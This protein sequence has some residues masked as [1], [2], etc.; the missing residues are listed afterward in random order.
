MAKGCPDDFVFYEKSEHLGNWAPLYHDGRVFESACHILSLPNKKIY[1]KM[2]DLGFGLTEL[3]PQPLVYN[4][5]SN[6]FTK[7]FR[8]RDSLYY[9]KQKLK[10]YNFGESANL[11]NLYNQKFY[12]FKK[13][14][15][16]LKDNHK[17]PLIL[18]E[19]VPEF[20]I[21]NS[22]VKI[23]SKSFESVYAT[24]GTILNQYR[25]IDKCYSFSYKEKQSVHFLIYVSNPNFDISYI[26][27]T[28]HKS[29][30]RLSRADYSDK[31]Y[32]L[33]AGEWDKKLSKEVIDEF[34]KKTGFCDDYIIIKES[35][36]TDRK[37][38]TRI[39]ND[40]V[41]YIY[42]G[43]KNLMGAASQIFK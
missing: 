5:Q 21:S 31:N 43:G 16:E 13:G 10:E 7:Y 2:I 42:W 18:K 4:Y 26:R 3:K 9:A 30:F 35:I 8:F 33:L 36:V 14:S 19:N 28:G 27:I 34:F 12:Y 25:V 15:F 40:R 6:R 38:T 17:K 24:P 32:Y 23:N 37:S 41:H 11:L 39:S 20:I 1:L 22:E 29:L